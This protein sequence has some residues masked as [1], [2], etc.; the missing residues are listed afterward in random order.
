[1]ETIVCKNCSR[2]ISLNKYTENLNICPECGAYGPVSAKDRIEMTVDQGS[3][4]ELA[5]SIRSEDFLKFVDLKA[6]S[7]RLR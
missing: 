2:K 3:F 4:N 1:M 6:Y 7:G 5:D